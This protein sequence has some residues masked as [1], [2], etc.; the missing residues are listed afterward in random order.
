[1]TSRTNQ[2]LNFLVICIEPPSSNP[3]TKMAIISVKAGRCS[4]RA[5][6]NWVDPQPAKGKIE[7]EQNDGLLTFRTFSCTAIV[8][9]T[10]LGIAY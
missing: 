1:M 9:V 8:V 3:T 4:R 7:I 5:D 6:T 10:D 2:L